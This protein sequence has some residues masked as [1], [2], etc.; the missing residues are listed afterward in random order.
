VTCQVGHRGY[1]AVRIL[2]ENGFTNVFN[3]DGGYRLYEVA[4]HDFNNPMGITGA[5][6]AEHVDEQV[7]TALPDTNSG[8]HSC[9]CLWLTMSGT[10]P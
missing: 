3:V 1:L 4:T 2:Q 8:S 9:R 7:I 6:E 10:H 5:A